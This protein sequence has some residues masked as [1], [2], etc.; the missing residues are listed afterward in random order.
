M[1]EERTAPSEASPGSQWDSSPA[2][3]ASRPARL[4][5]PV[6]GVNYEVNE[7]VFFHHH[8]I[9]NTKEE[10]LHTLSVGSHLKTALFW[11]IATQNPQVG[12]QVDMRI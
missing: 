2:P 7:K 6:S 10:I 5:G 3:V 8:I 12:T 4:A 11:K 1:W 9:D